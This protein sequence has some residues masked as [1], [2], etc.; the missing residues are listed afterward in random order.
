M[1]DDDLTRPVVLEK[2]VEDQLVVQC[3]G[4]V[5]EAKIDHLSVGRR[6]SPQDAC[7]RLVFR[8]AI[9]KREAVA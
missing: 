7:D 2:P 9:S 1:Q 8:H 5:R 3:P 6:L 4:H